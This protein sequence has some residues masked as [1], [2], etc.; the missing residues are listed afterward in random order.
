MAKEGI[1]KGLTKMVT[2]P[3]NTRQVIAKIAN[4]STGTVSRFETIIKR[5]PV[6]KNKVVG[7]LKGY[8]VK[9]NNKGTGMLF[10]YDFLVQHTKFNRSACF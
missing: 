10:F 1:K 6:H 2:K 8:R 3:H 9:K 4:V 5:A 7:H